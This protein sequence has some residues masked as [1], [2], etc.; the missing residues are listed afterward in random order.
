MF[1][2]KD[3]DAGLSLS[4]GID[5]EPRN[6]RLVEDSLFT[7]VTWIHGLGDPHVWTS[8]ETFHAAITPDAAAVLPLLRVDTKNGPVLVRS[9]SDDDEIAG[10]A[11]ATH[12]RLCIAFGP[13]AVTDENRDDVMERAEHVCLGELQSY[14]DYINGEVFRLEIMDAYGRSLEKRRDLYGEEYARHVAQTVF[15]QHAYSIAMNG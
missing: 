9:W 1:Q 11:F 6:P 3:T 13:D 5:P 10:Y 2:I 7:V 8:P 4:L 12:E 15:E 14:D